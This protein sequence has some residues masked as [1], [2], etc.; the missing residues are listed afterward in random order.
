MSPMDRRDL[1]DP[2]RPQ[3]T[4]QTLVILG[5]PGRTLSTREPPLVTTVSASRTSIRIS[6]QQATI[7]QVTLFHSS[8]LQAP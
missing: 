1:T 6:I 3:T 4:T 2:R 5:P 8:S 7:L